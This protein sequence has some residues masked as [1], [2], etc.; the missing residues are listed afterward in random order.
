MIPTPQRA[1]ETA[2]ARRTVYR[3]LSQALFFPGDVLGATLPQ[4]H[5][6]GALDE[7]VERLQP[8]DALLDALAALEIVQPTT[9]LAPLQREY[10]RL[11]SS[12]G[13][14]DLPPY[15]A[16]YLGSHIFMQAQSMADVAGFYQAFG[17]A[18]DAGTERPDHISAELEFMGYLCQ[19]EAY[20]A[21]H[22][23]AEALTITISAEK[24]FL[25]DHLGRWAPLFLRRF[26][27]VTRQPYYRAVAAFAQTFL[28]AEAAR[29]GVSPEEVR[30]L[31]GDTPLQ[32]AFTCGANDG[33]CPLT[34]SSSSRVGE[35]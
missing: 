21:E 31:S 33:T 25:V 26:E 28:A 7:A 18:M 2:L 12:T 5:W 34:L 24:R 22:G 14:S 15:G 17:V 11:F 29:L 3:C 32:G 30:E 4:G 27:A 1:I 6:V 20:A 35:A 9:E 23:L 19:K 16:D 8:S 13:P 10:I